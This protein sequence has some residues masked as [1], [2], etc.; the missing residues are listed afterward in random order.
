[1]NLVGRGLRSSEAGSQGRSV[2]SN[3]NCLTFAPY[4]THTHSHQQSSYSLQ[5]PSFLQLQLAITPVIFY[6]YHVI[7]ASSCTRDEACL[8]PCLGHSS[9]LRVRQKRLTPR[10]LSLKFKLCMS[11]WLLLAA[12]LQPATRFFAATLIRLQ[13]CRQFGHER[14]LAHAKQNSSQLARVS[15]EFSDLY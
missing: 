15:I 10:K 11:G 9:T 8:Q 1:M 14:F 3:I 13:P 7:K 5:S 4:I 6:K 2:I 12:W